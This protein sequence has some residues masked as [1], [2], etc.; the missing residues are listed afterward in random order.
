MKKKINYSY[1]PLFFLIITM[2]IIHRYVFIYAD[3][4]YYSRDAK[5]G[6]SYLPKFILGQLNIN[7]RVWVH[8]LLSF[9]VRYDALLFRV[10]NPIVI[11]IGAFFISKIAFSYTENSNK[12]NVLIATSLSSVLFMSMP[13]EIVSTTLYYAA[14][15]LNYFYPTL[16]SIVF[17]YLLFKIYENKENMKN[18]SW[19]LII[20][21][22]FSGSSTQQAGMIGIGFATVHIFYLVLFK[23]I[24]IRLMYVLNIISLFLGYSLVSYGSIKRMMF[25]K[26]SGAELNIL[27]TLSELLINNIFSKPIAIFVLLISI[28][29]ILIISKFNKKKISKVFKAFNVLIILALLLSIAAY[30]YVV[31]LKE[32]KFQ[33][34]TINEISLKARLFYIGFIGI[35]LFSILY[36]GIL[37]FIDRRTLY[38][39]TC[40]I[41]A[42]GAQF[43]MIVVDSRFA[44]AYKIVFPSLLLM[45]IFIVYAFSDFYNSNKLM[46]NK[47]LVVLVL[48]PVILI[49]FKNFYNNLEGYKITSNEINYNLNAI[50]EYHK[51][52]NKT[53]LR[54]EKVPVSKYGYNL[55]NWNDMP[56]FMKQCYEISEDT[57]IEYIE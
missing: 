55:G 32:Y 50:K 17:G 31:I 30:V 10:V 14:C 34:S 22:F 48:A 54:L 38:I 13:T 16:V 19:L 37:V 44:A 15:G 42:I 49:S 18:I 56:Y 25:E 23:K 20:L 27:E 11:T 1:L 28:S 6:L 46:I 21:A 53:V 43:M 4:L 2:Y 12:K 57:I 24:K 51:G 5:L 29:S 41:N 33:L 26:N 39:L 40:V 52:V 3:D 9:L 47:V 8:V 35:Y 36:S 7:G 45:F